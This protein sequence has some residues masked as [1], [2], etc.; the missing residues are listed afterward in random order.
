MA[1]ENTLRLNAGVYQRV[2]YN[3]IEI[4]G[5]IAKYGFV[6]DFLVIGTGEGSFERLMDTYRTG[7]PSIRQN[8]EFDR[9]LE[10]TGSGESRPLC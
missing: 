1:G 2:R 6:D 7:M 9:A 3:A 5:G 8:K 4:P 10:E